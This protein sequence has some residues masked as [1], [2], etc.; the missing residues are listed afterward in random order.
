MTTLESNNK[1]VYLLG[2]VLTVSAAIAASTGG[3][4]I[5]YLDSTDT[6]AI[7]FYRSLAF[8]VMVFAY[9]RITSKEKLR[10][11]NLSIPFVRY[12]AAASLGLAFVLYVFAMKNTSVGV[13]LVILCT[14][15]FIISVLQYLILKQ[16]TSFSNV[17]LI[18]TAFLAILLVAS[19]DESRGSFLGMLFAFASAF[20]Y[21]VFIVLIGHQKVSDPVNIV[22]LAGIIA[23][24]LSFIFADGLYLSFNNLVITLLLGTLQIGGQYILIALASKMIKADQISLIMLLEVV[25]GPLLVWVLHN[26]MMD[27]AVVIAIPVVIS[28]VAL[29]VL[30]ESRT[31]H[32]SSLS[33]NN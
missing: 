33:M 24:V 21:S 15:P 32:R 8:T 22:L 5:R 29:S 17:I 26:E 14:A 2:V 27:L 23:T 3:T 7:L 10:S 12:I 11:I 4:F 18:S 16:R 6:W 19:V 13:V 25:L 31:I 28:C 30:I 20:C 1:N 9:T